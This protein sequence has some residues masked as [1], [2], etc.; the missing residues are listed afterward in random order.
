MTQSDTT[1]DPLER[2]NVANQPSLSTP[3]PE[4]WPD[5]LPKTTHVE[6]FRNAD[7]GATALGPISEW[8]PA[9]R[10]YATMVFADSRAANVYWGPNRIAF[11][12]E[13]FAPLL[14]EAHPDMMGK[15]L[16]VALPTVAED[17]EMIFNHAAATG[18]TVEIDDMAFTVVRQ[19]L[20]E[21]TWVIAAGAS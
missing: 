9:L 13:E 5:T 18:R 6:L 1:I 14:A 21:E 20:L 17:T 19:G 2:D 16:R 3:W 12:N 8:G 7:F 11:Y 10:S 15:P 4:S